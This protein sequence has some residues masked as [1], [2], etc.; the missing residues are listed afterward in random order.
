MP[1]TPSRTT[2][3]GSFVLTLDGTVCGFLTSAE[4]GDISAPVLRESTRGVVRKRLGPPAPEPLVLTFDLS[5][6]KIVYDWIAESWKG[7]LTAR[8]GSVLS[9][10]ATNQARSELVFE[11]A[12]IAAATIPAMDGT[13]KSPCHLALRLD[14]AETRRRPTSGPV[15]ELGP[16]PKKL[17]LPANFRFEIDGLDTTRVSKVEPLTIASGEKGTV[18]FPD[19]R[20]LLAESGSQTWFAWHEEFVLEG[21]N[22]ELNEKSGSLVFLSPDLQTELGRVTLSG[23]GIYRLTPERA[24][25]QTAAQIRRLVA[26]LYC[27]R[28][29][30]VVP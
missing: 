7:S 13:S 11:H 12:T 22:D 19:V 29:E 21:K 27:Q 28:M 9:V 23:L 17:W 18:D 10:D 14:P 2:A 3:R 25:E 8:S 30:L 16:K 24:R 4:G 15:A 20:A 6:E 5:L 26:G 1:Q